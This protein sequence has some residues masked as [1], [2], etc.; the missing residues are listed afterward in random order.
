MN[1]INEK[2]LSDNNLFSIPLHGACTDNPIQGSYG[3]VMMI[4][5]HKYI[6]SINFENKQFEC[7]AIFKYMIRPIK[8][9]DD[10]IPI[11]LIYVFDTIS[12][13]GIVVERKFARGLFNDRT[14]ICF[15]TETEDYI[16]FP[17]GM[18]DLLN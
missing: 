7:M 14:I 9:S 5:D 3:F 8:V 6:L 1:K 10:E 15:P 11:P 12:P 2:L 17:K 13:S 18:K 4:P 16:P